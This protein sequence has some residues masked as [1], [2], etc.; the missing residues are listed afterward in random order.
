MVFTDKEEPIQEG[1]GSFYLM[2]NRR[3]RPRQRDNTH[4]DHT[5]RQVLVKTLKGLPPGTNAKATALITLR[6]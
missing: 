6:A 2:W 4:R 3:G 1:I 5:R